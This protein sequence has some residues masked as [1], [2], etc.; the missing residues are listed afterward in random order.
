MFLLEFDVQFT[1]VVGFDSAAFWV[2]EMT[3][4][5]TG[6]IHSPF[7]VHVPSRK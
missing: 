4:G 3:P 7:L 2:H 1:L 6:V 5:I